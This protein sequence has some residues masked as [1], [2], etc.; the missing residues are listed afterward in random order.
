VVVAV[1]GFALAALL[2]F[3]IDVVG[4]AAFDSGHAI[5]VWVV[6]AA[7]A[8][9]AALGS[10]IN[11]LNLSSLQQVLTQKLARTFLGASNDSRVHPVGLT[12]LFR[13]TWPAKTTI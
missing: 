13:S 5:G 9:S 8:T 11:F 4:H 2:F 6:L 10:A 12:P 7:L 1:V 3:A